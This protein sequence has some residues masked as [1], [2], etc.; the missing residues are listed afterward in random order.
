MLVAKKYLNDLSLVKALIVFELFYDKA[1]RYLPKRFIFRK[2]WHI[3]A[4]FNLKTLIFEYVTQNN[5]RKL[6]AKSGRKNI[7]WFNF[8]HFSKY[9]K[10]RKVAIFRARMPIF[11]MIHRINMKKLPDKFYDNNLNGS[12]FEFFGIPKISHISENITDRDEW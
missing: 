1:P 2:K 8:W 5:H 12:I 10:D 7:N 6:L 11:N 9:Q 3:L 4:I